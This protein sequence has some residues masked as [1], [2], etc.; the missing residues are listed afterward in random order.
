ML[1]ETS[2]FHCYIDIVIS[3]LLYKQ[4]IV[5]FLV[6]NSWF[7]LRVKKPIQR[8]NEMCLVTLAPCGWREKKEKWHLCPFVLYCF[9]QHHLGS[10]KISVRQGEIIPLFERIRQK[11][12]SYRQRLKENQRQEIILVVNILGISIG[13]AHI[14]LLLIKECE[15]FSLQ[16]KRINKFV[17]GLFS[18]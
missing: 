17:I 16:R 14:T 6:C 11:M 5:S 18:S 9:T 1:D 4:K 10:A 2:D 15:C 12:R 8:G 13:S 7:T 3:L